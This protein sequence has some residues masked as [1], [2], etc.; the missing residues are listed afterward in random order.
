MTLSENEDL[1]DEA[2]DLHP[3]PSTFSVQKSTHLST[4]MF[5][6]SWLTGRAMETLSGRRKQPRKIALPSARERGHTEGDAGPATRSGGCTP[7]T[8]PLSPCMPQAR[9]LEPLPAPVSPSPTALLQPPIGTAAAFLRLSSPSGCEAT[10]ADQLTRLLRAQNQSKS[11]GSKV[12]S[13]FSPPYFSQLGDARLQEGWSQRGEQVWGWPGVPSLASV[14][15]RVPSQVLAHRCAD[16]GTLSPSPGLLLHQVPG[17]G[18]SERSHPLSHCLGMR[19]EKQQMWV[20]I[21][22]PNWEPNELLLGST[23]SSLRSSRASFIPQPAPPAAQTE[24][25][26]G[27]VRPSG[28]ISS[29]KV[30]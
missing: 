22:L 21:V 12:R 9:E 15:W 29:S 26:D 11:P 25:S 20:I 18:S 7:N 28:K 1:D 30:P 23:L 6:I 14:P 16:P 19:K 3:T 8:T 4:D 5:S 27:P 13:I 10:L 17:G 2:F 24:C